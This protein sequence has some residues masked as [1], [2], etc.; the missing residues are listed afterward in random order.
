MRACSQ[1]SDSKLR[2]Q[3]V[4]NE[5]FDPVGRFNQATWAKQLLTT[6]Q[7]R[8]RKANGSG[9]DIHCWHADDRLGHLG[10]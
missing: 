3:V 9:Y 1:R 8:S 4:A 6:L 7:A 10:A 5:Y 2:M